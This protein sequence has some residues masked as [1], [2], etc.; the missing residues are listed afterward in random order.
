MQ[1]WSI[2]CT[3]Y[4]PWPTRNLKFIKMQRFIGS[5]TSFSPQV[6]VNPWKAILETQT[7]SFG[8]AYE[9]IHQTINITLVIKHNVPHSWISFIFYETG[10]SFFNNVR[11]NNKLQLIQHKDSMLTV[12]YCNGT[13]LR[14]RLILLYWSEEDSVLPIPCVLSKKCEL[15]LPDLHWTCD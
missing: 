15:N 4:L 1:Y 12:N 7:E 3:V 9:N 8:I 6:R 5:A 10:S 11:I 2:F 13:N 14:I